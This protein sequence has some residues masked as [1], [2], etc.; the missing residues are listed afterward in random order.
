MFSYES[1]RSKGNIFVPL[2]EQ[3]S[4]LDDEVSAALMWQV[5]VLA[6]GG[7]M[8]WTWNFDIVVNRTRCQV[9]SQ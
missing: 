5:G 6:L 1:D 2:M 8:T 7:D 3:T 9:P 4:V